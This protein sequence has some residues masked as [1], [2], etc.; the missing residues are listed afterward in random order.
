M[1]IRLPTRQQQTLTVTAAVKKFSPAHLQREQLVLISVMVA[2]LATRAA[3]HRW[4]SNKDSAIRSDRF[5]SPWSVPQSRARCFLR[6]AST[7]RRSQKSR[8]LF[9][10][11]LRF[12]LQ[13]F[14]SYCYLTDL[15]ATLFSKPVIFANY[16]IYIHIEDKFMT[17]FI[18]FHISY[19]IYSFLSPSMGIVSPKLHFRQ[20]NS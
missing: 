7:W 16:D 18:T 8:L 6:G 3:L 11:Q 19:T 17:Y 13:G 5:R 1:A 20:I 14:S 4:L 10:R 9:A 2:T 12:S 15:G